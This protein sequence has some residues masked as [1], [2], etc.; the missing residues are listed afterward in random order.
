MISYFLCLLPA[1]LRIL[2][3]PLFACL[4]R[5][6]QQKAFLPPRSFRCPEQD[7]L[8]NSNSLYRVPLPPYAHAAVLTLKN[9][10]IPLW[11]GLWPRKQSF[12]DS[13]FSGEMP[14]GVPLVSECSSALKHSAEI[15]FLCPP[16]TLFSLPNANDF[17][18]PENY[19]AQL[20]LRGTEWFHLSL[21]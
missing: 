16:A 9:P 20:F 18:E 21:G 2:S 6:R 5:D 10:E 8:N 19:A 15:G 11:A 12:T 17:C 13:G 7:G 14:H 3:S 4:G 1:S